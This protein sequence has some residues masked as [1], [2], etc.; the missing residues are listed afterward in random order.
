MFVKT[1]DRF[2]LSNH[3][4]TMK[5][6]YYFVAGS[7]TEILIGSSPDL[8]FRK[9]MHLLA[10][11]LSPAD[12]KDVETIRRFYDLE[13]I[14]SHFKDE[15]LSEYGNYDESTLEEALLTGEG[16][17]EYVYDFLERF[18]DTEER[19]KHFPMLISSYYK[20]ETP[21]E[22]SFLRQYLSFEREWRYVAVGFRAKALGRDLGK[23][24][25]HED[26]YDSVI[27]QLLA[28]KDT[29][30]FEP[31]MRYEI[32]KGV[33]DTHGNDPYAL[34]QALCEYRMEKIGNWHLSDF[35]SIDRILTYLTQVILVE[36]WLELDKK[37]GLEIVD[38]I[39]KE[40]S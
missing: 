23:E 22:E 8:S 34:N 1:L 29:P 9:L 6:M 35:F 3:E 5:S 14:R 25:Q 4:E 30:S 19:L 40:K 2:S 21:E 13:N 31:P 16:F 24:L 38:T 36:T 7:L 27:A 11:N 28:Q 37:K 32:L 33:F 17:P 18:T 20:E 10:T 39:V 26:P 12:M 15:E